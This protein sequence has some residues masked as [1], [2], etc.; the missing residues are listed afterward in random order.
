[1]TGRPHIYERH[2]DDL[3]RSVLADRR[4]RATTDLTNAVSAAELVIIAVGTPSV[5]GAIDLRRFE[6]AQHISA[7]A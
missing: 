5:D 1:M 3:L 4:F 7:S 2:L 6:G